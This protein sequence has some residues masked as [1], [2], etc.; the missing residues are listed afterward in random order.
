MSTILA[1]DLATKTGWAIRHGDSRVSYGHFTCVA[2]YMRGAGSRWTAFRG[3]LHQ[4]KQVAGG[5]IDLCVYERI[6]FC[7]TTVAAQLYGGWR[8]VL[9]MWCDHHDI[10]CVGVPVGT[11]K[12]HATGNGRALKGM[13]LKAMRDL[14]YKPRDDNE[15]D[16]LALMHY[17]MAELMED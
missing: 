5:T 7:K 16:A 3:E 9:Q 6:D 15:A 1:L 12:K 4:L 13:M 17:A 10:E 14:G 11:I 8:A 2:N